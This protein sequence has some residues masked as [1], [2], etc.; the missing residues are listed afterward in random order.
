MTL[1]KDAYQEEEIKPKKDKEHWKDERDKEKLLGKTHK[2]G[3]KI[4][5]LL[6]HCYSW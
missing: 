1:L 3:S 4:W 5:D 2:N 6:I